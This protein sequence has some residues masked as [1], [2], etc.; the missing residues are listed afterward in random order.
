MDIGLDG[1]GQ[2]G[3]SG[4]ISIILRNGGANI[5]GRQA[6]SMDRSGMDGILL[7]NTSRQKIN[8]MQNRLLQALYIKSGV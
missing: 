8:I 7:R 5:C 3:Y 4:K 2:A 1:G 6:V